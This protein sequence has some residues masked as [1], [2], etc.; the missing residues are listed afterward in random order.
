MT[1]VVGGGWMDNE[2]YHNC[3]VYDYSMWDP[4][5]DVMDGVVWLADP[6]KYALPEWERPVEIP[7]WETHDYTMD[8]DYPEDY[9][10]D[11]DDWNGV[12]DD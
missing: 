9:W 5:L 3:F 11:A 2:N 6:P 7:P 10:M 1:V 12:Y 8:Y 4:N